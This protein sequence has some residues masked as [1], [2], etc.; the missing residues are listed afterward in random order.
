MHIPLVAPIDAGALARVAFAPVFAVGFIA[1]ALVLLPAHGPWVLPALLVAAI[2]SS[3][4]AERLLPY[5]RIW[6][7][8]FGDARRDIAHALVNEGSKVVGVLS[9]PLLGQN[10]PWAGPWPTALPLVIQLLIAVLVADIGVTLVHYASH[11]SRLLRRFH[12]VHHSVQRMY[13]FNG[14][15]KHPLHQALETLAGTLPL[16]LLGIPIDVA[17][18]LGFAVSIQLLLQHSNVDMQLGFLSRVWAVAPVHRLHHLGS[19]ADGNVNFGLF[20]CFL[21]Y[22]LGTA[23]RNDA[24][25]VGPGMIGIEDEP[26]FPTS[27][28]AQLVEPFR[29]IRKPSKAKKSG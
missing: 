28:V 29:K 21:D 26:D 19:A 17:W 11:R 8:S 5:Q 3:L 7:L 16:L 10:L 20:T 1:A 15:L 18:L 12:A 2:A 4:A 24:R 27:Y 13:G 23:R 25:R 6:N 9:V 14:L 22:A